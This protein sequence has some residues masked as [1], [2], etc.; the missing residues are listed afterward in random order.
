MKSNEEKRQAN[1]EYWRQR[2]ETTKDVSMQKADKFIAD[3]EREYKVASRNIELEVTD[4]LSRFAENEQMTLSNAR[5]RLNANELKDFKMELEEYIRKGEE[6][7][8]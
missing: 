5:K 1:A 7:G 8:I 3:M 6:N 2:V 4:F